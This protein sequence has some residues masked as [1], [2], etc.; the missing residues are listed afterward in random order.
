MAGLV[1]CPG[2]LSL[3][4]VQS[5]EELS[6]RASPSGLPSVEMSHRCGES[7]LGGSETRGPQES[8][9]TSLSQGFVWTEVKGVGRKIC[10]CQGWPGTSRFVNESAGNLS[11]HPSPR[12]TMLFVIS[13]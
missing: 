3:I 4:S 11:T 8:F 13:G 12:Q 10:D 1:L 7:G 5:K 6:N 9:F 2:P